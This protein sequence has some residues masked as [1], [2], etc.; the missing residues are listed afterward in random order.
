MGHSTGGY[1]PHRPCWNPLTLEHPRLGNSVSLVQEK[2]S[3]VPLHH[4][5]ICNADTSSAIRA[6]FGDA[7]SPPSTE[8]ADHGTQGNACPHEEDVTVDA[9]VNKLSTK[10]LLWGD[11]ASE[12]QGRLVPEILRRSWP[13]FGRCYVSGQG[14]RL[15]L[16]HGSEPYMCT[17]PDSRSLIMQVNATLRHELCNVGAQSYG[18]VSRSMPTQSAPSTLTHLTLVCQS[19]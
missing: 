12:V 9:L 10:G 16:V 6:Q 5:L 17:L 11:L 3:S 15:G 19:L 8:G 14:A 2:A 4:N 7:V 13:Q 18:R 1:E